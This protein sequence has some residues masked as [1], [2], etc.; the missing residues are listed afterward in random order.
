MYTC[1]TRIT[2]INGIII[3]ISIH[4][5]AEQ[6]LTGGR[7]VVRV[8]EPAPFGVIVAGLEAI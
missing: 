2:T 7:I 6:A 4:I 1:T 5:V 8:D 3:A